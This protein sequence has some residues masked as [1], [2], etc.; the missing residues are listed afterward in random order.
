V[1]VIAVTYFTAGAAVVAMAGTGATLAS[2]GTAVAVT[3]LA[4]GAVAG[5]VA[6]QLVGMALGEREK[7]SW[8]EVAV[9]GVSAALT[10]GFAAAIAPAGT[11][12]ASAASTA[13]SFGRTA[14]T[15]V[16]SSF[17]SYGVNWVANRIDSSRD[18]S[19]EK[20]DWGGLVA[21]VASA[22][23]GGKLADK[24]GNKKSVDWFEKTA[25]LKND[26]V[27]GIVSGTVT[28][29]VSSTV[30]LHTRKL[31]GSDEEVDYGK[32]AADAFGNAAGNAIVA[33]IEFA[34]QEKLKR[35]QKEALTKETL[36]KAG[37]TLERN[38]K[39][40]LVARVLAVNTDG[41]PMLDDQDREVYTLSETPVNTVN[42]MVDKLTELKQKG[43]LFDHDESS[44]LAK[45]LNNKN[46]KNVVNHFSQVRD[47]SLIV[48]AL[49]EVEIATNGVVTKTTV[50]SE[51]PDDGISKFSNA[52][53]HISEGAVSTAGYIAEKAEQNPWVT[54]I[55]VA[56]V[57][58]AAT[59][60]PVKKVVVSI[61]KNL[62]S[63]FVDN[64][65]D[66][67]IKS[68]IV[69]AAKNMFTALDFGEFTSGLLSQGVGF[70][71]D[72]L[73]GDASDV[74]N[75]SKSIKKTQNSASN[76]ADGMG[77]AGRKF[78]N[79]DISVD[80]KNKSVKVSAKHLEVG[81][82]KLDKKWLDQD[83]KVQ[84]LDPVTGKL[85]AFEKGELITV[86]HVL[87]Q[88]YFDSLDLPKDIK[89]KIMNDSRN[90]MPLPK[91]FNS[92]KGK[93]IQT[94]GGQGWKTAKGN[95]ISKDY[96]NELRR[97]Q[98]EIQRKVQQAIIKHKQG[99]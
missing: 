31:L 24:L 59:G 30:G 95:D 84:Y 2:A 70:G 41:T 79:T 76:I 78:D 65:I 28:G 36:E 40:K 45:E 27:R 44:L 46:I 58:A 3:A 93:Q 18:R 10:A 66:E 49:T 80:Y 83:G 5:S 56:G 19:N 82:Y 69:D 86:D 63:N 8:S 26:T 90:L 71:I 15:A 12:T 7:F 16:F 98:I 38:K 73:I 74:I 62:V 6:G 4:A 37:Y 47:A 14:A 43:V 35:E 88:K 52:V 29:F 94:F 64:K 85:K 13:F 17:S 60:G 92:S 91:S 42:G 81:G 50:E 23:V 34:I 53:T 67:Y 57:Q 25:L 32:I 96:L 9:A 97:T 48:G 68:P 61:A 55:V 87:P 99:G 39:G 22:V 89:D 54:E 21:N 11:A 51:E 20:F 77:D 75:T 1:V 72:L 33:N